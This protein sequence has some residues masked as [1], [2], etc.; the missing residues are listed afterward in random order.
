M[1]LVPYTA[2]ISTIHRLDTDNAIEEIQH[3]INQL[4]MDE[5]LLATE[6]ICID[7][8]LNVLLM[9]IL[10]QP[11]RT[12]KNTKM[13]VITSTSPSLK[14]SVDNLMRFVNDPPSGLVFDRKALSVLRLLKSDISRYQ[15]DGLSQSQIDSFI[16][17]GTS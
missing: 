7:Y 5:P 15:T 16:N 10:L 1:P 11:Y 13:T 17:V 3:C 6:Y 8:L 9:M 14:S 4:R 2:D 12:R